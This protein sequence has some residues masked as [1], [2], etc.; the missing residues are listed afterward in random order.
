M[1]ELS[2]PNTPSSRGV[3]ERNRGA[4]SGFAPPSAQGTSGDF[5]PTVMD[6]S[7]SGET[8]QRQRQKGAGSQREKASAENRARDPG[9]REV[10]KGARGRVPQST[11]K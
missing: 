8:T 10:G 2:V 6:E 4:L 5:F 3:I 1:V 9:P 11:E 7:P